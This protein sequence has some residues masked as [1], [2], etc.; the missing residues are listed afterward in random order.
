M[1]KKLL[2]L[3]KERTQGKMFFKISPWVIVGAK[4]LNRGGK[5]PPSN[6]PK[7]R[8]FLLL[9]GVKVPHQPLERG[10]PPF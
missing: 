4:Y 5:S 2:T 10:I 6:Y 1:K 3:K 9:E 7:R 8:R